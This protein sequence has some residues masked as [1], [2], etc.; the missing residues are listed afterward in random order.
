MPV[1]PIYTQPYNVN[2][3]ELVRPNGLVSQSYRGRR[4]GCRIER[5]LLIRFRLRMNT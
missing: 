3:E 5:C 2:K 4:C 1:H